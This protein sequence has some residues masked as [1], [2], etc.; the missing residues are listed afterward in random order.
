V[1]GNNYRMSNILAA[2]GRGQLRVLPERVAA[3][4]RIFSYYQ[5]ALGDLP[6]IT[7]MPQAPYGESNRWLTCITIDA[8]EFGA[9]RHDLQ[10]ALETANIESRPVWKPL[11]LQ[12]VFAACDYRG[13]RVAS[14]L[15]DRGLCLPSGSAMTN[16]D[17]TRV[18]GVI[19][20][21]YNNACGEVLATSRDR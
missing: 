17:L 19:H 3:R 2:I 11:H 6:G 16:E 12:P 7:F 15:F 5:D 9:S 1:I 4:R 18:I 20:G 8:G 21:V 13:A 14:D 10:Q